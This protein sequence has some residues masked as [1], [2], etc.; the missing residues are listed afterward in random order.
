MSPRYG[1]GTMP[2]DLAQITGRFSSSLYW[3][4][5]RAQHKLGD[6]SPPWWLKTYLAFCSLESFRDLLGCPEQHVYCRFSLG[7]RGPD[8]KELDEYVSGLRLY[9]PSAHGRPT[10]LT[11]HLVD[12]SLSQASLR[13]GQGLDDLTGARYMLLVAAESELVTD[14]GKVLEDCLKLV[15]TAAPLKVLLFPSNRQPAAAARRKD[16][17]EKLLNRNESSTLHEGTQWLFLA[18]PLFQ[19][20]M[21]EDGHIPSLDR[22]VYTLQFNNGENVAPEKRYSLHAEN[23]WNN[24]PVPIVPGAE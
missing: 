8:E 20:W 7:Q 5:G 24:N 21:R 12:F 17:I 14:L 13:Q 2:F 16:A 11:E 1:E 4:Y 3:I 15:D 10:K 19:D 23:W 22:A 18:I 6:N 9:N